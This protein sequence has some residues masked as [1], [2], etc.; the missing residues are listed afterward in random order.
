MVERRIV[1]LPGDGIGPEV[2]AAAVRVLRSLDELNLVFE[3][4]PIGGVAIDSLGTPLPEQTLA[5]CKSADAV[6]LGAVGGPRW[7]R[8]EVR[9]EAGL[10]GLRRGLG[11][12]ANLRPVKPLLS[13]AKRA[14][15]LKESYLAGV[16]ILILRELT[17]DL[18]FG[19]P[20]WRRLE[21]GEERAIDT[22][23]YRAFEVRRVAELAF[24]LAAARRKS[25]TSVDKA[26]VLETSRL[27]RDVVT[28]VHAGHP[29][30]ALSHQ[31]VDSTA[32]RLITHANTFDVLL[33][34]N[35]FGDILSDEAAVLAGSL[36]LLPSASLGEGR[37]GLYEPIHGSAPDLAGTGLA[38]PVGT[39]LSTAMMLRHSLDRPDLARRV[40]R[41]VE[42][43]LEGGARTQDLGGA[44]STEEMTD[45]IIGRGLGAQ[46]WG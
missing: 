41:A 44:H 13:V 12:F 9:P 6:L 35:M 8:A 32:M 1:L 30:I 29:A 23:D 42:E 7:D 19:Q 22:A 3:T 25:V 40:E 37:L 27:W 21:N 38:N 2:V 45:A 5:A 26:N 33:T 28:S 34:S 20:R 39:I 46:S 14:S 31:L 16:D 11:L 17:G 24:R 18:Y 43:A 36:G 15:P 10:L 4:H